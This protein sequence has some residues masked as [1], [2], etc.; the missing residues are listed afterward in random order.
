VALGIAFLLLVRLLASQCV[1]R[2]EEDEPVPPQAVAIYKCS[3]K[4]LAANRWYSSNAPAWKQPYYQTV[5]DCYL[6]TI[7]KLEEEYP[8]LRGEQRQAAVDAAQERVK[9][10]TEDGETHRLPF[11]E[12]VR[13]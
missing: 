6:K 1:S 2:Q 9:Q 12:W 4:L 8:Q 7:A 10:L 13:K 11:D 3:H 5:I